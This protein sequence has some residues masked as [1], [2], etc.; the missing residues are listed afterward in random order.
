M[1]ATTW[2]A[3][4]TVWTPRVI[5][6]TSAFTYS[7]GYH[8]ARLPHRL[9]ADLVGVPSAQ[10]GNCFGDALRY[11]LPRSARQGTISHKQLVTAPDDPAP[12]RVLRPSRELTCRDPRAMASDPNAPLRPALQ[13]AP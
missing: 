4:C 12:G 9:G 2:P 3:S 1:P 7:A 6:L 13:P 10:A 5:V 8:L 11:T